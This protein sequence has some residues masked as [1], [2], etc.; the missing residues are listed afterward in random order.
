MA[1]SG[2]LGGVPPNLYACVRLAIAVAPQCISQTVAVSAKAPQALS[3]VD[4][5]F[6]ELQT[7]IE[8][9]G[10]SLVRAEVN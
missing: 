2:F 9:A 8:I 1:F 5:P 7:Q 6:W 3:A 4:V 10:A